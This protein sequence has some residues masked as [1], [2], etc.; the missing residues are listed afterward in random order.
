LS[1]IHLGARD[2]A[3]GPP[4]M[5]GKT[6]KGMTD[7]LLAWQTATFPQYET[8]RDDYTVYLR[9]ELVVEVAVDGVQR[10]S[11]YRGGLAMRFARVVRY[12]PDKTPEQADTIDDLARL[13]A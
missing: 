10:S 8:S 9:P 6:F 4:I 5:V 12:R 13:G 11:R 1:N 2:P 7:E 3:G